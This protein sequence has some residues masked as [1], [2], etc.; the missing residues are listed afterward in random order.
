MGWQVKR[1]SFN[2][3]FVNEKGNDLISVKTHTIR[4]NYDYWKRFE[5]QEV[6]L[7]IWE[8]KP[9][10]SKQRVFCVKRIVSVQPVIYVGNG[11]HFALE[12]DKLLPDNHDCKDEELDDGY[13][14][15]YFFTPLNHHLLGINDG[16][17]DSKD[18]DDLKNWFWDYPTGKMAII[19]FTDFMY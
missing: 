19:H 9:Y 14:L 6:A 7:F 18:A 17:N 13:L 16:F 3:Q 10:R 15:K 11:T 5:C 1:I 12:S 8:G 4:Q 2:S